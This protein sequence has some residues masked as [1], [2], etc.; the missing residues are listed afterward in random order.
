VAAERRLAVARTPDAQARAYRELAKLELADGDP[1]RALQHARAAVKIDPTSILAQVGLADLC[2][3]LCQPDEAYGALER[4][5]ALHRAGRAADARFDAWMKHVRKRLAWYQRR[6]QRFDDALATYRELGLRVSWLEAVRRGAVAPEDAGMDGPAAPVLDLATGP[7]K[8]RVLALH[9]RSEGDTSAKNMVRTALER[10]L[11]WLGVV[12]DHRAIEDG[13]PD[14]RAMESY[15]GV[16][17]WFR[18]EWM[19]DAG[20]YAR[21]LARQA[22][23]GRRVVVLE[24]WGCRRDARLRRA[25]AG[26][27]LDALAGALGYRVDD[28]TH[29]PG[30][31]RVIRHDAGFASF[32]RPLDREAE[33]FARV[34][35]LD[36]EMRVHLALERVDRRGERCDAILTGPRGGFCLEGYAIARDPER[37]RDQWRLD[38]FRFLS[39][40]LALDGIPR[41]D[42]TTR[43]GAR[44]AY[45]HVD[46]GRQNAPCRWLPLRT[47]REA[48]QTQVLARREMPWSESVRSRACGGA[49]LDAAHPS[50]LALPPPGLAA[51]VASAEHLTDRGKLPAAAYRGVLET[52]ERSEAPR[53]LL[54]VGVHV[55]YGLLATEPGMRALDDVLDWVESAEVHAV[56]LT[57]HA[58]ALDGFRD[59]RIERRADGT[60]RVSGHGA[61]ATVRFDGEAAS[62][63]SAAAQDWRNEGVGG[64]PLAAPPALRARTGEARAVDMVR[65]RG[66][67]GFTR[68][69]GAMYVHLAP[70]GAAE[71]A[72]A[73][74][75]GR[76]YVERSTTRVR[77]ARPIAR[78]LTLVLEGRGAQRVAL[79]GFA[80]RSVVHVELVPTRAQRSRVEHLVAD[81]QGRVSVNVPLA[82]ARSLIARQEGGS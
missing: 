15:R 5:V 1:R 70:D 64:G 73:A 29:A 26:A 78:G 41:P 20:A 81:A 44:V 36:P 3:T 7:V 27:D 17:T 31:L 8:R 4:A 58:A 39:R 28:A 51:V 47:C 6:H 75:P 14:D 25:V 63:S 13:L 67:L 9:K 10:P 42:A 48:F 21:W 49:R 54:P 71:I 45:V 43:C 52:F 53:R 79:G 74:A 72:L 2:E 82:G 80:P 37:G 66:V 50:L 24:R 57:E 55:G 11:E 61:C 38:V 19:R 62:G 40:A 56:S 46:G 34:E 16:V 23:A 59:A 32:E 30:K 18:T 33:V 60:W 69:G 77:E 12:V 65:S 35:A 68:H 22:G 76:P